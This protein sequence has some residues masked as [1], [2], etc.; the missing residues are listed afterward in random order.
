MEHGQRGPLPVDEVTSMLIQGLTPG[1]IYF[2]HPVA[3]SNI[4]AL[5]GFI[6]A[7]KTSGYTFGQLP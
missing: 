6:T 5:P 7:A 3:D 2:L 1:C 4:A